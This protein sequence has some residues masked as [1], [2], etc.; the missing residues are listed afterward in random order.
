MASITISNNKIIK[1]RPALPELQLEFDNFVKTNGKAPNIR[2][3]CTVLGI[4][5]WE[6]K[7]LKPLAII[8]QKKGKKL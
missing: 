7:I 1:P 6:P 3:F 8:D 2:Q 4:K 5:Y